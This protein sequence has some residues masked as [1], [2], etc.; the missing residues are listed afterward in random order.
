MRCNLRVALLNIRRI[1]GTS[2]LL[3]CGAQ[4]HVVV[5]HL[6][7]RVGG[8]LSAAMLLERPAMRD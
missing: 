3:Y 4:Y 8:L 6:R 1:D 5:V 7:V 2:E